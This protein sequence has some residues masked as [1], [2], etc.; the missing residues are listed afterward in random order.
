MGIS[1][2]VSTKILEGLK[3][4]GKCIEIPDSSRDDLPAFFV[5]IGYKVGVEIGVA[6]GEFSEQLCKAGLK[7]YSVDPWIGY[8]DY[9]RSTI[10]ERLDHEYEKT[11]KRLAPYDSVILRKTSMEAVKEFGDK[12]IDFVYIDGHHGLKYV[13]EDLY[14]WSKKVKRGGSICGHDYTRT[15]SDPTSPYVCHVKYAVDAYT[16]AFKIDN[17]YLLGRKNALEGE[18]RDRFRSFLWIKE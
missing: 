10:Q 6:E 12:S 14:E 9:Y 17:W 15:R 18:K 11:K 16:E 8:S 1:K 5:E 4:K 3:L 7:V 2:G 13:V